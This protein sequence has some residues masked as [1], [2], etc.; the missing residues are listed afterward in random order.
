MPRISLVIPA[1]NEEQFLPALL[2]SVDVARARYSRGQTEVEVIV[3]NNCSTD[4]TSEIAR[5]RGCVVADVDKPVI[6]ASRNGGALAATG[7]IVAFIDADCT[8]HPETFNVIE[9]TMSSQK[10]VAGATGARFDRSSL[11]IAATTL[12]GE[13]LFFLANLDIGVVFCR[14]AD[15]EAVGGYDENLKV[16]EDVE[17]LVALKQLGKKRGQRFVRAKGAR[18]KT[19][20]RKFDTRGD[21][22][23]FTMGPPTA[24][25][26]LLLNRSALQKQMGDSLISEYWYDVRK[27][28]PSS[29]GSE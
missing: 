11:G 7:D 12:L 17:F 20:A 29:R 26:Y 10:A 13:V 15:W 18:A 4:R 14:R 24:V 23:Y 2:D 3:A 16:A 6:A 25:F 22:H 8:I 27:A 1:F 21:W 19:S 9:D 28:L 5:S